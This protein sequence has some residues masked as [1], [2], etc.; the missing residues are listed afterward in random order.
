MWL[1][2]VSEPSEDTTQCPSCG[3]HVRRRTFGEMYAGSF[4]LD[5]QRVEIRRVPAEGFANPIYLDPF[6]Q[7]FDGGLYRLWPGE[8]YLTRGGKKLHREV[9]A[10]AFGPI[11]EG[12][13]I[14]HR[15]GN[16]L[17]N[18]IDNLECIPASEHLSLTWRKR[19]GGLQ[20]HFSAFAR[21]RAAEWHKSEE[22]RLWHR[23]LAERT[24][25]WTKW[26]REPRDCPECGRNFMA[27]VRK[28]GYPQIF[29]SRECKVAAYR[30]RKKAGR[31]SGCMVPDGA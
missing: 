7:Y 22:G 28:S 25:N 18:R 9:W 21:Q 15:D 19:R 31:D 12:C 2:A 13:H 17:N 14:H 8:T 11:P 4:V 10:R 1:E 5:G 6:T 26:K 16:P 27:L 29:C 24:R 20:E 30:K 23:R 3:G